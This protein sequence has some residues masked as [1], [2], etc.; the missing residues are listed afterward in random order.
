MA[1][2]SIYANLLVTGNDEWK[3]RKYHGAAFHLL[4]LA[5]YQMMHEML[6]MPSVKA[7]EGVRPVKLNVGEEY[8]RTVDIIL[9]GGND[10]ERFVELKSM[11]KPA[12]A[13]TAPLTASL[14]KTWQMNGDTK[15]GKHLHKEFFSDLIQANKEDSKKVM[16]WRFHRFLSKNKQVTGPKDA[17]MQWVKDKLCETP[18]GWKP[19]DEAWLKKFTGGKTAKQLESACKSGADVKVQSTKAVLEEF[20][21]HGLFGDGKEF[22][23]GLVQ[24][25]AGE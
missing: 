7:I 16:T 25:M 14:F 18:G 8:K 10:S 5:Y 11:R 19:T 4:M 15:N 12:S 3:E 20:I 21:K 1:L 22:L 13:S 2:Y 24:E 17:D 6:G 23:D 9:D